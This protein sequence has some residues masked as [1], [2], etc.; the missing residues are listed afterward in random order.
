MVNGNWLKL[1]PILFLASCGGPTRPSLYRPLDEHGVEIV[2]AFTIASDWMMYFGVL[3][4]IAGILMIIFLK[5]AKTGGSAIIAG[6]GCFVFAQFLNYVGT[7]ILLFSLAMVA[8][9]ILCMFI[10]YKAVTVG[11]PWLEKLANK[12]LNH[13][14]YIGEF[15]GGSPVPQ[16]IKPTKRDDE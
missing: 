9:I 4:V 11:V 7:H 16:D 15:Q 12:D 5:M 8:I 14:G 6:I 13:D 10:Y 1:L 2:N 3:A